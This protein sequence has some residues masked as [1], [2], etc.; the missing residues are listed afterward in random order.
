M[1][2]AATSRAGQFAHIVETETFWIMEGGFCLP[3]RPDAMNIHSN[4]K[5]KLSQPDPG[6]PARHWPMSALPG[7]QHGLCLSAAAARLGASVSCC[8]RALWALWALP[9]L[10]TTARC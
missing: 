8:W 9:L 2:A 10:P 7:P 4:E 6:C 5:R 3:G 1:A